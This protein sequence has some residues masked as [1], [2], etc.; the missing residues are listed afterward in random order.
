M[1]QFLAFKGGAL[2]YAQNKVFATNE[3]AAA[4]DELA[5]GAIGIF[6]RSGTTGKL[7]LV[8]AAAGLL[9][10][11]GF[12]IARGLAAG[13]IISD[14]IE[15]K[16]L[17]IEKY[18]A[19]SAVAKVLTLGG[20][21]SA[22]LGGSATN[23]IGDTAGVTVVD[24]SKNIKSDWKVKNYEVTLTAANMDAAAIAALLVTKI[25]NDPNRV[26]QASTSGATTAGVLILTAKTAGKTFDAHGTVGTRTELTTK[27]VTTAPVKGEGTLA[28][29]Q[30]L[31]LECHGYQGG[32]R[33]GDGRLGDLKDYNL[34][35]T[36]ASS[37]V[38]YT[39][40]WTGVV[41]RMGV[42]V[43]AKAERFKRLFLAI[44]TGASAIAAFD[45]LL[46][47]TALEEVAAQAEESG[48]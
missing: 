41:N 32:T 34:I 19:V 15:R 2:I 8:T 29:L 3:T 14:V 18:T 35:D 6:S 21:S 36:S 7:T 9:D 20:A 23:V 10:V 42:P 17:A 5:E 27:T 13:A 4:P 26:V 40:N 28:N 22:F 12:I 25:N 33:R 46:V 11:K 1:K 37:H 38:V 30:E 48:S 31:Q 39:L 45:T 43:D 47:A 24:T 16:S 44:P